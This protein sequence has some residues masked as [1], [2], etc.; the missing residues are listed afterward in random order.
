MK[1]V[2]FK[3]L[4]LPDRCIFEPIDCVYNC[5][6]L[7]GVALF[8]YTGRSASELSFRQ[9]GRFR[10]YSRASSDWWMGEINGTKGLIPSAYIRIPR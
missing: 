9:G 5:A 8:D 10:L 7:E 6:E 1:C 2:N 3:T 4:S